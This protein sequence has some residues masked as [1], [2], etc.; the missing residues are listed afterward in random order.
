M[1]SVAPEACLNGGTSNYIPQILK[2]VNVIH[3]AQHHFCFQLVSRIHVTRWIN[4]PRIAIQQDWFLQPGQFADS[5]NSLLDASFYLGKYLPESVYIFCVCLCCANSNSN[6]E[7]LAIHGL[8]TYLLLWRN[9]WM[10]WCYYVI[11]HNAVNRR[12]HFDTAYMLQPE[13]NCVGI[14]SRGKPWERSIFS[15]KKK[16]SNRKHPSLPRINAR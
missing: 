11:C 8:L 15:M 7:S 2:D 14:V 9:L 10:Y 1:G 16:Q 13:R 3:Y 4:G 6:L 12:Q 5:S